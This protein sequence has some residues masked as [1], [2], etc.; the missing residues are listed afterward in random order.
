MEHSR[1]YA[2]PILSLVPLATVSRSAVGRVNMC[3]CVWGGGVNGP[4]PECDQSRRSNTEIMNSWNTSVCFNSTV[5]RVLWNTEDFQPS[6]CCTGTQ[7]EPKSVIFCNFSRPGREPEHFVSCQW[8][9]ELSYTF[10]PA[11]IR[12]HGC[13]CGHL[14]VKF[15]N[16]AR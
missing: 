11:Y 16:P 3:V 8:M 4:G 14:H 9:N 13:A 6:L 10:T 5:G 15:Q 7:I 2:V 1:C 12:L